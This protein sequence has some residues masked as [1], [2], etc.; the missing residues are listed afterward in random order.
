MANRQGARGKDQATRHLEVGHH[1]DVLQIFLGM[2]QLCK[3]LFPL[4]KDH[5]LIAGVLFQEKQ[6]AGIGGGVVGQG[7]HSVYKL[8]QHT[9]RQNHPLVRVP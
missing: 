6:L 9:H 1:K 3:A 8:Q 5:N 7:L 2:E 4:V